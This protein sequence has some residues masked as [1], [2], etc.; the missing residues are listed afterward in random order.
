MSIFKN[1]MEQRK[2]I[3]FKKK[4]RNCFCTNN[5][6]KLTSQYTDFKSTWR[7]SAQTY[8]TKPFASMQG[9]GDNRQIDDCN[10]CPTI[11]YRLSFKII[12]CCLPLSYYFDFCTHADNFLPAVLLYI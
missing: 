10:R 12:S 5:C 8:T 7:V 2:L 3:Q 9:I 4:D 1:L 6:V 11:V